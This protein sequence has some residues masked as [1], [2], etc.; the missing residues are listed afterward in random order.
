MLDSGATHSFVHPSVVCS[1]FATMLK[2]VLLTVAVTNGKKVVF[3]EIAE[4][5]L[6]YSAQDGEFQV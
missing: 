5:D 6:V 3:S 1:T 2:G 4:V